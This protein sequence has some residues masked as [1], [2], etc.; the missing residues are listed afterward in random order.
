MY[1][2]AYL[3]ISLHLG[4]SSVVLER[5]VSIKQSI[6]RLLKCELYT[7]T[8]THYP[9]EHV[10]CM[11]LLVDFFFFAGVGGGRRRAM[12][13]VCLTLG[14]C[15]LRTFVSFFSFSR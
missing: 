5:F 10:H 6:N 2:V 13:D 8:H 15:I 3:D 4:S 7:H 11:N 9:F 12:C 14:V 1:Q